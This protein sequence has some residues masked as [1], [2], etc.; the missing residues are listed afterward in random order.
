MGK[1]SLVAAL[2]TALL[3]ISIIAGAPAPATSAAGSPVMVVVDADIGVDD[4]AAIA[5]LLSLK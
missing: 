2:S 1:K 3:V 4:A 5:Y